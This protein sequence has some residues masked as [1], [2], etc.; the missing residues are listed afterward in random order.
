MKKSHIRLIPILFVMSTLL[1]G[2]CSPAAPAVAEEDTTAALSFTDSVGREFTISERPAS[3]VSL[4]PSI[5]ETLYAI[6]AGD[7][8]VGRTDYCNYPEEVLDVPVV[9]G[10]SSSEISTETIVDIAP[11]LVI[12][13]SVYQE[14]VMDVLT[15]AGINGFIRESNSVEDI[16]DFMLLLGDITDNSVGARIAV[17]D[18]QARINAITDVVATI[19]EDER[20]TVFYEVWHDP[21]MTTTSQTFIGELITMAGGI[22][23]F[24]DLEEDYPTISAEE[25]IDAD[26][27]VIL[28]PSSHG[29]QLTVDI[30]AAREGWE[31]LSAVQNERVYVLDGDM[32]SRDGPRVVDAL[33]DIAQALYPDYFEE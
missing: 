15:G 31:Q 29:D 8:V 5:T 13:G 2:A 26:P 4:A 23:I 7:L 20:V 1:L 16:M 24:A 33:E 10:F 22:N 27:Q 11:D 19:P 12:G 17:A 3:I 21:Y 28:G 25:I 6:G 18:M 9:G 14:E 30:I 32:V